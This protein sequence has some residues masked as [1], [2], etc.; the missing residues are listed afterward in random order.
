MAWVS[1]SMRTAQFMYCPCFVCKM[2]IS[3]WCWAPCWMSQGTGLPLMCTWPLPMSRPAQKGPQISAASV[4]W[5]D[6]Q[7]VNCGTDLTD[8][9]KQ[10]AH[11][12]VIEPCDCANNIIYNAR[13]TA[14]FVKLHAPSLLRNTTCAIVEGGCGPTSGLQNGNRLAHVASPRS[15][16]GF[17]WLHGVEFQHHCARKGPVQYEQLPVLFPESP[18]FLP[19]AHSTGI[20]ALSGHFTSKICQVNLKMMSRTWAHT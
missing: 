5:R 7:S 3:C 13:E 15:K 17:E 4:S 8:S 20:V 2:P 16:F 1:R 9:S 18:V 19:P 6:V 12:Q 10:K 14:C 11:D